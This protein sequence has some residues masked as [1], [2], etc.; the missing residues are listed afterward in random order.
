[1]LSNIS[2]DTR[3]LLANALYF[4]GNWQVPFSPSQTG[5]GPF[6]VGRRRARQVPLMH[7]SDRKF[8]YTE[9]ADYQHIRL[10][11]GNGD[12]QMIIVLPRQG[13]DARS[14][15]AS[16]GESGFLKLFES[17]SDQKRRG[18]ITLPR[19]QL[20]TVGECAATI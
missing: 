6:H 9:T 13:L 15:A 10:P 5:P 4:K 18:D 20:S 19:L 8:V 14:W 1:M 3:V 17:D 2:L 11:F 7:H 12:L 16:L